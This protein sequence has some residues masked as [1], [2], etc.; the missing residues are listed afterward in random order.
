MVINK[1]ETRSLP[2]FCKK[3]T[4]VFITKLEMEMIPKNWDIEKLLFGIDETYKDVEL[5][6]VKDVP[7]LEHADT[8][9]NCIDISNIQIKM[10][11]KEMIGG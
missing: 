5:Y 7:Q 2:L 4:I 10:S 1:A 3:N 9:W 6:F 11:V 8:L